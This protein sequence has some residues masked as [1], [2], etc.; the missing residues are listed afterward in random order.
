MKKTLIATTLALGLV[1]VFTGCSNNQPQPQTMNQCV[2]PDGSVAKPWVCTGGSD[3][4]GGVFAIGSAP[5]TPA[6][7][8]EQREEAMAAARDALSR[9]IKIKVKNMFK[10]FVATTGVGDAQTVDKA[11]QN[12]SKQLSQSTLVGSKQK[13]MWIDPKDG[14]LYI[15]VGMP[16]PKKIEQ[17]VKQ[18]ATTS[19]KNNRA[20]WQKFLAKK[21]DGE[22]DKAIQEEFGGAQQ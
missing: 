12:V 18:A 9:Q 8:S 11:T 16:D 1:S 6:G 20:L 7:F 10:K 14:T 2:L 4:E 17:Q 21:A 15:L 13:D 3:M 19:F 5:K 22:L